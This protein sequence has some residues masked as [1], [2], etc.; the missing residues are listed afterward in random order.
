MSSFTTRLEVSPMPDGR[1]WRLIRTFFYD[2]GREGSGDTIKVPTGFVTDFA[3][4]PPQ[5]WWLIPPWG[6]YGKAAI[7][8]DWLYQT[9]LR[10]RKQADEIFLE[11]MIILG[12]TPWR[13]RLMYRGVRLFGWLAWHP[14]KQESYRRSRLKWL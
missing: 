6:K 5:I 12:V 10:T 4:S 9:G 13:R 8:H 14:G 1:R 3:S 2:V 7:I 11:G